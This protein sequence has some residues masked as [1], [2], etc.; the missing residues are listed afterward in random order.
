[1]AAATLK[2]FRR[3][4]GLTLQ[5]IVRQLYREHGAR[6]QVQS[7]AVAVPKLVSIIEAT[8]TLANRQGFQAMSLREL[9]AAAGLSLGGLYAYIR[10]KDELAA[11]IQ[12][13]G[14]ALVAQ[15]LSGRLAGISDP[16]ERLRAAIRTHL[17]LSELLRAWFFFSFMEARHLAPAEREQALAGEAASEALLRELIEQGQQAGAFRDCDAQLAAAVLKAMLQ[18]W[19]LKR[20]KYRSRAVDVE[21]YA[22]FVIE[23]IERILVE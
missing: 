11:L 2:E 8:L 12:A 9:A 22:G 20:A 16:R 18:D 21:R 6:F 1:M 4:V 10:S 15:T 14:R 23:A 5:G 3:D 19:Y 17:Y 13:H 7:E